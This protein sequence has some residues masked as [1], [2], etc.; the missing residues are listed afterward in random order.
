MST[1]TH[2]QL[3]V[4]AVTGVLTVPSTVEMLPLKPPLASVAFTL[5]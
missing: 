2:A 3:I 4:A 1:Y 5:P